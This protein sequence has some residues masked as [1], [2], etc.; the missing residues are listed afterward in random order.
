LHAAPGVFL[1]RIF[2]RSSAGGP[3]CLSLCKIDARI[4][5][6][7]FNAAPTRSLNAQA[8]IF[9]RFLALRKSLEFRASK[10]GTRCLDRRTEWSIWNP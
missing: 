4:D 9:G 3:A 7:A 5:F 10:P 1:E 6:V 8:A 2:I